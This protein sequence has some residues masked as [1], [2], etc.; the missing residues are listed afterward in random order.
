MS[1]PI[2]PRR[3]VRK[4]VSMTV[5]CRTHSG[6]RDTGEIYDLSPEGCCIQITGMFF[7][8]GGRIVLRP[9]GLEAFSGVVRWISG[10]FAGVEFD[11]PLY[12]PVVDHLALHNPSKGMPRGF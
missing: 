7:K 5:Q 10:D 9:A 4:P 8:V 6:L 11:R 12:G 1:R 2:I 3:S